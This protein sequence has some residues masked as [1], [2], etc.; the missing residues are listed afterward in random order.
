MRHGVLSVC[1]SR[2]TYLLGYFA[3]HK[4]RTGGGLRSSSKNRNRSIVVLEFIGVVLSVSP[5]ELESPI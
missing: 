5:S 2:G 4:Y 1:S 3:P